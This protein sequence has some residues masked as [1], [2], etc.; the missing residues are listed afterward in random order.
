MLW[1]KLVPCGSLLACLLY[2]L[3]DEINKKA[4]QEILEIVIQP[5]KQMESDRVVH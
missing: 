1:L 4:G 2:V 5:S 3:R